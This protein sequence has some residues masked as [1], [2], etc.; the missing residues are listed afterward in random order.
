MVMRNKSL[1][2]FLLL[3]KVNSNDQ[4]LNLHNNVY[5]LWSEIWTGEF[6]RIG[7]EL[8]PDHFLRQDIIPVIA[9][10]D[11]VVA[12]HLYTIFNLR[13]H[14]ALRNP[15]FTGF[16][17]ESVD[18]FKKHKMNKVMSM[19]YLTVNPKWR[20]SLSGIPFGEIMIGIATK[21]MGAQSIDACIGTARTDIGIEKMVAKYGGY[22]VEPGIR[23]YNLETALIAIPKNSY[24]AHPENE[25]AD[26]IDTLWAERTDCTQLYQSTQSNVAA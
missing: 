2:L 22:I 3:P 11:E 24:T 14:C 10:E 5:D 26:L 25:V 19:E 23:R 16:K 21:I 9:N 18:Y 20:K 6:S 8:K 7:S 17:S 12:M 15:Y 13:A 4:V 1:K